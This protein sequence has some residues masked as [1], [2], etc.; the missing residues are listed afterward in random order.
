MMVLLRPK[1]LRRTYTAFSGLLKMA[2]FQAPI[3]GWFSAPADTEGTLDRS[4]VA[5]GALDNDDHVLD[6][7]PVHGIANG[8]L[9][10][11]EIGLVVLDGG[12]F[13]HDAA[14]EIGEHD[15]GAGLGTIDAQGGEMFGP[16]RLDTGMNHA[17][18]LVKGM[19]LRR[20]LLLRLGFDSHGTGPPNEVE[21]KKTQL[22]FWK[23]DLTAGT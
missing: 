2:G 16:H 22:P 5:S 11:L 4:V 6:V 12:G 17:P 8:P 9:S 15:L 1:C 23:S 13:E 14:V 20:A 18:R 21:R 3:T 10:A 7:A 19:G